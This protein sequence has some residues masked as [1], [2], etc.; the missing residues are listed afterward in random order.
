MQLNV[1]TNYFNPGTITLSANKTTGF[2]NGTYSTDTQHGVGA[3]FNLQAI[4]TY[5]MSTFYLEQD[6]G[7]ASTDERVNRISVYIDPLIAGVHIVS[8]SGHDYST[9]AHCSADF[10][11]D[12]DLG[13]DSD[14]DAFFACL[15]GNCCPTCES[16]DFNGD[17]DVGTDADIESFFR[18]LAGG[19]C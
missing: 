4:L 9:P 1:S 15:A 8:A 6:F 16:A 14:I 2:F 18:V 7:N 10:N 13:T 5:G 12:G 17:G 11:G 3:A 19:P